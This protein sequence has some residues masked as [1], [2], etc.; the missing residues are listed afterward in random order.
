VNH[1]RLGPKGLHCWEANNSK[2]RVTK[3][4]I[5]QNGQLSSASWEDAMQLIVQKSKDNL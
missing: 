1:G 5:R 3:P 2:D 4:L